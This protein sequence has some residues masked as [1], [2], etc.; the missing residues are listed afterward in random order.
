MR[1]LAIAL[2]FIVCLPVFAQS[3]RKLDFTQRLTAVD[4]SLLQNGG[5]KPPAPLTLGDVAVMALETE[6]QGETLSG[7]EKFKLDTLARKIYRQKDV[8]LALDE[9]VMIKDRIG[10]VEPP[11]VVGAAWRLLDPQ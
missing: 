10:K 9:L 6:S 11:I 2:M 7:L 1:K 8:V 3:G 4:G 5:A